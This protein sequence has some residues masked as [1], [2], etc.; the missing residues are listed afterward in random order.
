MAIHSK[1]TVVK[2]DTSGGVLTDIST[3]CRE[4]QMPRELDLLN[5]TTFGATS[6]AFLSGF[7]DGTVTMSGPWTRAQD[8]MFT[9]IF[10]AF[11]AGTLA[12]VS[13]EYGPEGADTGDVKHSCELIMTS[14]EPGSDVEQEVEWSAEFQVTG[15]IT[16]GTY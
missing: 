3:Y 11:R 15:A 16:S 6:K 10:D 1:L 5:V 8:Q 12:S 7:A 4:V 14:Y 9:A 2:L 13:F